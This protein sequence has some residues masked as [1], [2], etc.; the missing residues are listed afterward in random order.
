MDKPE[1][2]AAVLDRHGRKQFIT[3]TGTRDSRGNLRHFTQ[4]RGSA[5]R[6]DSEGAALAR[7][8]DYKHAEV[9]GG[10]RRHWW[11]EDVQAERIP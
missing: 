8:F 1:W 7:G 6:F 2:A 5:A 4:Y 10:W 3:P 9:R 11:I